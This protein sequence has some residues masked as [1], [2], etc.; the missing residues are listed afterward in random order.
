MASP[1][2]R[3]RAN[4]I[5]ALSFPIKLKFSGCFKGSLVT[6][7]YCIDAQIGMLVLLLAGCSGRKA[8]EP[9]RLWSTRHCKANKAP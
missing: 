9:G 1:G 5:G 2:N 8:D 4:C 7:P 3:H 6:L